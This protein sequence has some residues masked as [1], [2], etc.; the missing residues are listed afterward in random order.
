MRR[1]LAS[2][3]ALAFVVLAGGVAVGAANSVSTTP[4]PAFVPTTQVITTTTTTVPVSPGGAG[5]PTG[6]PASGR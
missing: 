3:A 6:R 2:A 5:T 1:V 4:G